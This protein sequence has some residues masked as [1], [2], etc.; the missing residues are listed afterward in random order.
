MGAIQVGQSAQH[1][2]S[3]THRDIEL[4]VE[5]SGDSND[6]HHDTSAGI[7]S[8]L[9][10]GG[11]VPGMLS[12]LVFAR[13]F[14]TLLPGHGSVYRTLTIDFDKPVFVDREYVATCTVTELMPERR[15]ARFETVIVDAVSSEV[16]VKGTAV[17]IHNERLR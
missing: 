17:I 4:Y 9:Q 2:F 7:R 8:P 13:I 16:V 5:L 3:L 1:S 14:G 12:G 11:T 10:A 6:I 15:R